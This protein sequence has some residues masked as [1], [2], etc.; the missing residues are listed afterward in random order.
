MSPRPGQLKAAENLPLQARDLTPEGGWPLQAQNRDRLIFRCNRCNW[1]GIK[2]WEMLANYATQYHCPVC[3]VFEPFVSRFNLLSTG[4][5]V[6]GFYHEPY[7]DCTNNKSGS[8]YGI[9]VE[10]R[11]KCCG[12]TKELDYVTIKN[13]CTPTSLANGHKV[14]NCDHCKDQLLVSKH[15][16]SLQI[17]RAKDI[18]GKDIKFEGT[19]DGIYINVPDFSTTYPED[20]IPFHAILDN[21]I[22][23][24]L[25]GK[26]DGVYTERSLKGLL[27]DDA[28]LKT[29]CIQLM[30]ESKD[31]GATMLY[32]CYQPTQIPSSNYKGSG[33]VKGLPK[34]RDIYYCY[35]KATKVQSNWQP[36]HVMRK[37]N[38]GRTGIKRDQLMIACALKE[39]FPVNEC[40]QPTVWREDRRDMFINNYELDIHCVNLLP[41]H[42]GVQCE[43]NGYRTHRECPKTM[44]R[45][46][47]KAKL[48]EMAKYYYLVIERINPIT[49]AKALDAVQAQINM[50][51]HDHKHKYLTLLNPKPDVD[52]ISADYHDRISERSLEASKKFMDLL[53]QNGH[54]IIGSAEYFLPGETFEYKCGNCGQLRSRPVKSFIDAPTTHCGDCKGEKTAVINRL[55]RADK[56][57]EYYS[58]F[59]I[60]E[61]PVPFEQLT[62]PRVLINMTEQQRAMEL[63]TDERGRGKCPYCDSITSAQCYLDTLSKYK[64]VFC[65]SCFNT[66]HV[67]DQNWTNP[68][69]TGSIRTNIEELHEI[70]VSLNTKRPFE[71]F[72]NQLS[73]YGAL[74]T[75]TIPSAL[76]VTWKSKLGHIQ[77]YSLSEWRKRLLNV[78]DCYCPACLEEA[79]FE[80]RDESILA[81]L[82]VHINNVTFIHSNGLYRCQCNETTTIG[83]LVLPHPDFFVIPSNTA[84]PG[85]MVCPACAYSAGQSTSRKKMID[86]LEFQWRFNAANIYQHLHPSP[87]PMNSK[88]TFDGDHSQPI[89]TAVQELN[90]HCSKAHPPT[91]GRLSNVMGLTRVRFCKL[92]IK[93]AGYRKYQDI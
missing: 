85:H 69:V 62:L 12:T 51:K 31:Y 64:T 66:G 80:V 7:K 38:F 42:G 30:V 93:D 74:K 18:W 16:Q 21:K 60:I 39:L 88:V 78:Y 20:E 28:K 71:D 33:I 10:I 86:D 47:L 90:F 73:L 68:T 52:R 55:G 50:V 79:S 24:R 3:H 48:A 43:Y 27:D 81:R 8:R 35:I 45:D 22:T 9:T 70:F 36:I 1:S 29:D 92:C 72:Y 13:I 6:S 37:S 56:I 61:N 53:M 44:A 32:I 23:G 15:Q 2:T 54:T 65:F 58:D 87:D 41:Q 14:L 25:K 5:E 82:R 57:R 75:T 89:S 59:I 49:A 83:G 46:E 76:K 4:Y 40:G 26:L 84:D 91:V 77:T 17:D 19:K 34:K 67:Q 63:Q 11:H